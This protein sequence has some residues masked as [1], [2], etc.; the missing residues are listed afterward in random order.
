MFFAS[1]ARVGVPFLALL[2]AACSPSSPPGGGCAPY[3]VP[4]TFDPTTPQVSFQ[5][6][7]VTPI[8]RPQCGLS[9]ACH[10]ETSGSISNLYLGSNL[11]APPG[12]VQKIYDN[13]VGQPSIDLPAM[14]LVAPGDYAN[15]FLMHKLDGDQCT[16][17]GQCAEG[18][19][20]QSMPQNSGLIEVAKRDTIRRWIAQGAQNN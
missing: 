15:S 18:D 9:S 16:L 14:K 3:Q 17:N 4:S 11:Q 13:L 19:C 8:F 2:S 20:L 5:N 7:I 6:D 1:F 12:D 10:Q